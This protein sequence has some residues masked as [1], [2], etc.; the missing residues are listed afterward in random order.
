MSPKRKKSLTYILVLL[1]PLVVIVSLFELSLSFL[2]DKYVYNIS[3]F[4]ISPNLK[5]AVVIIPHQDDDLF[6]AGPLIYNL[7]NKGVE[8]KVV[9]FT[10]GNSHDNTGHIRQKESIEAEKKLGVPEENVTCLQFPNRKQA[11]TTDP[12]G[13]SSIVLRNSMKLSLKK[14][15]LENR[16]ELIVCSDFDFN[17]DH[18]LLTILFDE[19]MGEI[20]KIDPRY[21]PVVLKG[22]SYQTSYNAAKDFYGSINIRSTQK[23]T[24]VQNS[25]YETDIPTYGWTER[26]RIP[27]SGKMVTHSINKNQLYRALE[28]YRSVW[29]RDKAESI[30]NGDNVFWLKRTDNLLNDAQI[31]VSSGNSNYV[32]D[33]K[34]YDCKDITIRKKNDV[35]FSEYLWEADSLDMNPAIRVNLKKPADVKELVLYENPDKD[36]NIKCFDLYID[37]KFYNHIDCINYLGLP[38]RVLIDYSQPV[39]SI[40]LRNFKCTGGTASIVELE[41]FDKKLTD[42]SVFSVLKIINKTTNDFLYKYYVSPETKSMALDTYAFGCPEDSLKWEIINENSANARM[43]NKTIFFGED[44]KQCRVRVSNESNP[45]IYDEVLFVNG[46]SID[47]FI[48]NCMSAY[49]KGI[50]R[51]ETAFY[52]NR[53]VSSL[54]RHTT[55]NPI[56]RFIKK[57][58][59]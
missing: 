51:I 28:E 1:I 52:R 40:E 36:R 42:Y 33:F 26:L 2:D 35:E 25:L 13:V 57:S 17:R 37:N 30:I 54:F 8:V 22:F 50:L 55:L 19:T 41:L 29:V 20:L 4:H 6:V 32:A 47:R 44:F 21:R 7:R 43:E 59:E 18:R 11:D 48:Y 5:K 3:S 12:T 49:D 10:D 58:N 38:S 46:T 23:P 14:V 45:E 53:F 56:K 31:E 39:N 27:L 34:L 24:D 16:P 9:F 15:V